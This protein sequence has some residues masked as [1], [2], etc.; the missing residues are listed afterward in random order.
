MLSICSYQFTLFRIGFIVFLTITSHLAHEWSDR[1]VLPSV[2]YS[3]GN[4]CDECSELY[5]RII[6]LHKKNKIVTLLL[7]HTNTFCRR[8]LFGVFIWICALSGF[9]GQNSIIFDLKF[10]K[11]VGEIKIIT[12]KYLG[13]ISLRF[14]SEILLSVRNDNNI[15]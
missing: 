10:M 11:F 1:S 12:L 4:R 13:E 15:N 14:C 2:A 6:R 5:S 9:L 7:W 8:F 3:L